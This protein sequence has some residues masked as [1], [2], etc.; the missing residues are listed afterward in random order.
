MS[1]FGKEFTNDYLWVIV[2]FHELVENWEST[3]DKAAQALDM[4]SEFAFHLN[5]VSSVWEML[6]TKRSTA[7]SHQHQKLGLVWSEDLSM[8]DKHRRFWARNSP[9]IEATNEMS[10]T[11]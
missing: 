4:P 5:H 10:I 11:E 8:S 1:W 9:E 3:L 2:T 7:Y 6:L